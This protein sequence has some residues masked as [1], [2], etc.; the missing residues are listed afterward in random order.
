MRRQVIR[1][2]VAILGFGCA[3]FGDSALGGKVLTVGLLPTTVSPSLGPALGDGSFSI[4]P[5]FER[6][7]WHPDGD[8][9]LTSMGVVAMP[10]GR[11]ALDAV[12][13]LAR[14]NSNSEGLFLGMD[15]LRRGTDVVI[16]P[17]RWQFEADKAQGIYILKASGQL[18]KP[19]L[20]TKVGDIMGD[21]VV[22]PNGSQILFRASVELDD[23]HDPRTWSLSALWVTTPGG[24]NTR[25]LMEGRHLRHPV[26]NPAGTQFLLERDPVKKGGGLFLIDAATGT[27]RRIIAA[28]AAEVWVKGVRYAMLPEVTDQCW[29]PSGRHIVVCAW[30]PPE[31]RIY[32]AII[33]VK[34][35][36]TRIEPLSV[37]DKTELFN[38]SWSPDG[39]RIAL[40]YS[41]SILVWDELT[42]KA[43]DLNCIPSGF[44][45][46]SHSPCWSP[47]GK[48]IACIIGGALKPSGIEV[49]VAPSSGKGKII[50]IPIVAPP[51][52]S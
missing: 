17:R 13:K 38:P 8:L 42:K 18:P 36:Q 15:W 1:T 25:K 23:R 24:T 12:H 16:S 22:S 11:K 28:E 14:E 30:R 46:R 37:A 20:Q 43:N 33:N 9:L 29:S 41:R 4:Q 50:R 5:T 26:W 34:T 45:A 31:P 2:A 19:L 10:R 51:A 27:E 49:L 40:Y 39:R 44:S 35:L 47:D 32:L 3:L 21:P 52:K 6:V 7:L 48:W